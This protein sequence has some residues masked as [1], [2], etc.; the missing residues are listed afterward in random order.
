M[1][2]LQNQNIKLDIISKKEIIPLNESHKQS[3]NIVPVEKTSTTSKKTILK[4]EK[5]KN[6]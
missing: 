1:Y 4:N 2:A 3:S 6:K 5:K